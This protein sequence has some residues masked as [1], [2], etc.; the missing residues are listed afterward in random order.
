VSLQAG[1]GFFHEAQTKFGRE[2]NP[3]KIL[4][5]YDFLPVVIYLGSGDDYIQCNHG[6]MEPGFNPARLLEN[7]S[8]PSFQL[9]GSLKQQTYALSHADFF[10][11]ADEASKDLAMRSLQDFRPEDPIKPNVLGFMWNDFAVF[12]DEPFFGFDPGRAYI[13]GKV[14]TQYILEHAGTGNTQLRAV[15]RGHQQSS[16]PNPMMLRLVA[17]KGVFQLWQAKDGLKLKNAS[18]AELSHL[19]DTGPT[20]SIPSGSV[21]TFNVAPDSIYGEGNGYQ[22]DTFGMLKT[23]EKFA[24][25]QLRV[26]N[27]TP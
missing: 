23:A 26:I 20:R 1:Y 27:V 12:G 9:L 16:V 25:W 8:S 17:S 13:Y 7:S 11:K 3:A 5:A 14:A 24:D 21:W 6:G 19:L 22:F 2:F 18:L 4:R 10:A 15:F